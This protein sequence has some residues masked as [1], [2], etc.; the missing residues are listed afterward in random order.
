MLLY[1]LYIVRTANTYMSFCMYG[2][3]SAAECSESESEL[4]S[5]PQ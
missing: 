3:D 1:I 2:S 4:L 5:M